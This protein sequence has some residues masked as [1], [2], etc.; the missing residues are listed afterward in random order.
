MCDCRVEI[1]DIL[2]IE[3]LSLVDGFHMHV[4]RDVEDDARGVPCW[5]SG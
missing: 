3:A 4:K 2:Q 1:V 5:S